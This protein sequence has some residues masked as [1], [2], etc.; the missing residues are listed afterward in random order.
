VGTNSVWN[1][2]LFNGNSC[3]NA[4][5]L[6]ESAASTQCTASSGCVSN[7]GFAGSVSCSPYT[8]GQLPPV[9]LSGQY[10]GVSTFLTANCAAGSELVL[11]AIASGGCVAFQGSSF[12]G[13][14]TG[15]GTTATVSFSS[16]TG[17]S[18]CQGTPTSTVSNAVTTGC[19]G[20]GNGTGGF[21]VGVQFFCGTGSA[22]C[23][24]ESTEIT[25]KGQKY[26]RQALGNLKGECVIP[27]D[28]SSS[29]V[30]I[31]TDCSLKPLQLTPDHLVYTTRGL[32]QAQEIVTGD[33]VFS[34]MGR[35]KKCTV[36]SVQQE[37]G[38]YFGLNCKESNVLADGIATSTFGR[39]H[40][41]PAAWM[42]YAG[43]L[44][45][46]ERASALGDA[47]AQTLHRVGL[48]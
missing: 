35:T 28:V 4:V 22:T 14:C 5:Q 10:V 38:K 44:I 17:S 36:N 11:T 2:V 24:H 7:G 27:H 6:Q 42:R 43:A 19:I 25:Y 12:Q 40:A 9:F 29:G 15:S 48:L 23:F 21:G 39:Y 31:H 41:L 1:N 16:W 18:T 20:G 45:G 8:A 30:A 3:G 32:V 47:I 33:Q 34:D 37:S 46:V 26:N 13:S